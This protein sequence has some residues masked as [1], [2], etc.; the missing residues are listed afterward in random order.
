MVMFK[1][2]LYDYSKAIITHN[3]HFQA[4]LLESWRASLINLLNGQIVYISRFMAL[5]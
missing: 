3:I 2:L 1:S 5:N 4:M